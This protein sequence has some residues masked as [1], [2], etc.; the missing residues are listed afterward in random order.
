[1]TATAQ[2]L[3]PS[4]DWHGY[5]L[6]SLAIELARPPDDAAIAAWQRI[7][8]VFEAAAQQ[9]TFPAP[10]H[11]P[12]ASS[13]RLLLA[14]R[15]NECVA[16]FE[17]QARNIDLRAFE[18]LRNMGQRLLRRALSCASCAC[19]RLVASPRY[20]TASRCRTSDRNS[21]PILRSQKS[22][23]AWRRPDS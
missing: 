3:L 10:G 15:E 20:G 19:P 8:A 22:A 21:K 11:A 18:L 2:L 23:L 1:M 7:A 16:I 13:M 9:G 6:Y 12:L 5:G 14:R 4:G 17:V